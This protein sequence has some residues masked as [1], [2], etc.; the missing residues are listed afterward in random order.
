MRL[1][2]IKTTGN[3][4]FVQ[5]LKS[6]TITKIPRNGTTA[7]GIGTPK[8]VG[9]LP[10]V[11]SALKWKAGAMACAFNETFMRAEKGLT[12]KSGNRVISVPASRG[13]NL[14][15]QLMILQLAKYNCVDSG[16]DQK[17]GNAIRPRKE[18][19][20]SVRNTIRSGIRAVGE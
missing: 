7:Y 17:Q 1:I 8:R 11:Q 9:V 6:S 15:S 13:D 3:S 4:S 2:R 19:A 10:G 20:P 12:A 16:D 14:M 18:V 5:N